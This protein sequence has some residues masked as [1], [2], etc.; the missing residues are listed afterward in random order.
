MET[1]QTPLL[2]EDAG[3]EAITLETVDIPTRRERLDSIS[4]V[5]STCSTVSVRNGR[6]R[7]IKQKKR[8]PE[9][10]KVIAALLIFVVIFVVAPTIYLSMQRGRFGTFPRSL[11][12]RATVEELEE[13]VY[14]HE[15]KVQWDGQD[16]AGFIFASLM[17][18]IAAGG[19][20][21]G[22]GVLVPTYIFILGFEPKYAIPLS[23][24]T[25]LG[26][27]ISNLILNIRKRHEYAD[28]PRIDWDIMLMMEP[29]TVAGALVGTFVNVIS[30]PWVITIMLVLLLTAT[31]IKTMKKGIKKY[32]QETA[33]FER[34]ATLKMDQLSKGDQDGGY[35]AL[36]DGSQ[37][38][39]KDD[40]AAMKVNP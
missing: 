33:Q 32:H 19:G 8:I 17:I 21:G 4:T 31:A 35:S 5:S 40:A 3:L 9:L 15:R 16:I 23:N 6:V 34:Q 39:Y 24:C 22:G 37:N 11:S 27:S 29:L 12:F 1:R 10:H 7:D 13:D 36:A 30:P 26:S 28:R 25:I 38:D 18:T 20:I 14:E 2:E